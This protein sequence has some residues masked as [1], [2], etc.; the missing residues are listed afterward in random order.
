[1][2]VPATMSSLK[3]PSSKSLPVRVTAEQDRFAKQS[4]P[5]RRGVQC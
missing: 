3:C 1:M 5:H 2:V 4:R